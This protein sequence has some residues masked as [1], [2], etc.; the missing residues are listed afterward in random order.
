MTLEGA[1]QFAMSKCLAGRGKAHFAGR[2]VNQIVRGESLDQPGLAICASAEHRALDAIHC[3]ASD[4]H[5]DGPLLARILARR[6]SRLHRIGH[7][8]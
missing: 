8:R 1:Q 5:V 3:T 4:Y 6:S 2:S 7:F